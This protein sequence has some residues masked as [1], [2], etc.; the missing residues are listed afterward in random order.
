MLTREKDDRERDY[1]EQVM[2]LAEECLR[3]ANGERPEQAKLKAIYE[4]KR[5]EYGLGRGEMDKLIFMRIFH[6]MPKRASDTLRIRYWRTGLH[7]PVNHATALAFAEA[8]ELTKEETLW[9]IQSWLDKRDLDGKTLAGNRPL[10][11]ER[12]ARLKLLAE[13]YFSRKKNKKDFTFNQ[14]RHHYFLDAMEYGRQLPDAPEF[15]KGTINSI[16]YDS[17]LKRSM[18]LSGEIPRRTMLRHLILFAMPELTLEKIQEQLAFFGYLPLEED[19]TLT[20]G[21]YCDRIVMEMV[22][23]FERLKASQGDEAAKEW[24]G[25]CYRRLDEYFVRKGRPAYR[26]L[27]FKALEND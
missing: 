21:E 24:F 8:L 2:R 15:L 14:F 4:E 13:E 16:N 3:M 5:A 1:T 11:Q 18:R 25:R 23:D 19:H 26:F 6:R 17:E 7:Y 20:G 10:Y 9:L 12:Y 27:H 22:R